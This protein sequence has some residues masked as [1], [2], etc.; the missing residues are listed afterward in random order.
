MLLIV[1][2]RGV[3]YNLAGT[4]RD[5]GEDYSQAIRIDLITADHIRGLYGQRLDRLTASRRAAQAA[6][7]KVM[8]RRPW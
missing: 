6:A 7:E 1:T 4:C 5:I 3:Y 2:L 8:E